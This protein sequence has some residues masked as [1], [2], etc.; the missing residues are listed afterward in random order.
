MRLLPAI[1]LS[2]P[3]LPAQQ[4]ATTLASLCDRA[5]AV[6][7]ARPLAVGQVGDGTLRVRFG[8]VRTLLGAVGTGFTLPEPAGERGERAC[9]RALH[10]LAPGAACVAFLR[11]GAETRLCASSARALPA[12]EPG[13]ERA[14]AGLLE[15][16]DPDARR[17]VLTELLA[18]DCERV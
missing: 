17:A 3:L 7:V 15:A 9:G 4:D 6:V 14:V 8:V 13:L 18:S 5:D 10:G 1:L 16:R 11:T 2:G 12:L